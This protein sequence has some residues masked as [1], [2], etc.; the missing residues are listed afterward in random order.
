MSTESA[1]DNL[2]TDNALSI[3]IPVYNEVD[4]VQPLVDDVVGEAD[5][6]GCEYEL[7]LVNDGSTDG[8]DAALDRAS[9]G[10]PRVKVIHFA[11]NRGQTI[12]IRAGME[13]ATGT[14]LVLMDGDRQNDPSDIGPLLQ[15]LDQGFAC[16]SGWRKDRRD[17]IVR[18]WCSRL[19]NAVV[20]WIAGVPVHDL[21][22]TL[23]AYRADAIDPAEMLGEMHRFLVLYAGARGKVTEMVVKHHA[24]TA[25]VSK[26]G[27]S[28]TA[29]VIA[30]LL[31][32]R[33]LLKYPTRPSHLFARIAQ[34][35]VIAAVGVFLLGLVDRWVL[36]FS[37][38][39]GSWFLP[40]VVLAVGAVIVLCV[41]ASC[42]LVIRNR[43]V[44]GGERPYRVARTV[45]FDT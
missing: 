6:L 40:A 23:K 37:Q 34:Y 28:R 36:G 41:G 30:D 1:S 8:S 17:T 42:E 15:R 31:L 14:R 21:G 3:V 19:A 10:R 25:G 20:R 32:V 38:F 13:A 27:L 11:Q 16:V 9:A 29:R 5:K 33:I 2:K 35:M 4:N 18:R 12:A 26:Y 22:C 24:R 44:A 45:N 43:Y 39:L 7:I